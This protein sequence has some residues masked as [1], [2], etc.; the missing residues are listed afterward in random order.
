[1]GSHSAID[2]KR[3]TAINSTGSVVSI[4]N[5]R[6]VYENNVTAVQD[7]NLDIQEGEFISFVGPSGCG[8][9][10]IFRMISG[11][12]EPSYGT[13]KV[14]GN[15]PEYARKQNEISYV[16]QDA[17]LMPW[18]NTKKNVMLPLQLRGV[19]E[20]ER[21]VE[22]MRVLK[23]VGLENYGNALPR[24]LS[25]GMK[26]R[27]SIARALIAN[28]KLL[29]MDEPFGALDEITRQTLQNEL[30][31]IWDK[32][33]KMTTLFV[34]HNV[35]E[36]VYLSTRVIVMS[37]QPGKIEADIPISIP[38]P[39]GEVFRTTAAFNELVGKVSEALKY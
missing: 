8:K 37:Q 23:L 32:D 15:D 14:L 21:L 35:Y 16:F 5:V 25:G 33:T 6:K 2:N 36:A 19:P 7:V 10:T 24:Q 13:I 27:V 34:T 29:L 26:M 30:L 9:S 38:F 4:R 18:S 31:E 28:P 17:T 1:M 11:L 39:R 22:A 20:K 12:E 3:R